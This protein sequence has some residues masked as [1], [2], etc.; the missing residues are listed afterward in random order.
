MFVLAACNVFERCAEA[1]EPVI[2]RFLWIKATGL[3]G[4]GQLKLNETDMLLSLPVL[5]KPVVVMR[6]EKKKPSQANF[7]NL[8]YRYLYK[9]LYWTYELGMSIFVSKNIF[10]VL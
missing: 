1:S 2:F 5:D 7:V 4:A 6:R 10:I 3:C 9:Y 8:G